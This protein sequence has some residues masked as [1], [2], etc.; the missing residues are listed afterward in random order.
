MIGLKIQK[1]LQDDFL[2]DAEGKKIKNTTPNTLSKYS[3]CAEWCN[4]NHAI[5]VDQGDFYEVVSVPEPTSE[6]LAEQVRSKRDFLLEE[7]DYLLVSD[8]PISPEALEAVKVYRQALRDVPQ[9]EGFPEKVTFPE[10][11]KVLRKDST[12]LSLATVGI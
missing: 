4:A 11:P 7:T 2:V 8:Y 5:I 10:L 1:P 9:Q 6:E 12:G 3:A